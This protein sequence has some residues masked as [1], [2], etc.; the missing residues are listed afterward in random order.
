MKTPFFY[1]VFSLVLANCIVSDA[2]ILY[3]SYDL[4]SNNPFFLTGNSIQENRMINHRGIK[5]SGYAFQP[6]YCDSQI[7]EQYNSQTQG[8]EILTTTKMQYDGLMRPI[9]RKTYENLSFSSH[10]TTS[11]LFFYD[12]MDR[13]AQI[14]TNSSQQVFFD[15]NV[16]GDLV[17]AQLFQR[18]NNQWVLTHSDSNALTY[19]NNRL[20]SK[21]SYTKDPGVPNYFA[22]TR[23]L[24]LAFDL[25]NQLTQHFRQQT[26][27]PNLNWPNNFKA[28]VNLEWEM[29]YPTKHWEIDNR[30]HYLGYLIALPNNWHE[31]LPEP[32]KGEYYHV[33]GLNFTLEK[34]L[35]NEGWLNNKLIVYEDYSLSPNAHID[36]LYR[37]L[38]ERDPLGR[39]I[40]HQVDYK[41][42]RIDTTST[43]WPEFA[44]RWTYDIDNRLLSSI[45]YENMNAL[46]LWMDSTVIER[47][48]E[49]TSDPVPQVF[50]FTDSLTA[51]G[52]KRPHLRHTYYYG[53]FALP[54]NELAQQ[55]EFDIY[56]NP[57]NAIIHLRGLSSFGS[58]AEVRIYNAFGQLTLKEELYPEKGNIQTIPLSALPK[59]IYFVLIEGPN[60]MASQPLVIQ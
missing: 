14:R 2:Q 47:T 12:T 20:F 22:H 23:N 3:P 11:L 45:L 53:N 38:Y 60:G 25:N 56:P 42:R 21:V 10:D 32:T 29:G 52:I 24:N 51:N 7:V 30:P 5:L 34:R 48:Y 41:A 26:P 50:R 55:P 59:G 15:Y 44:Y 13:I 35:K 6:V 57:A 49:F 43:L 27:W 58:K 9:L 46:G 18:I 28:E 8:F 40:Y 31:L 1:L 17:L 54:V 33:E 19:Q 16:F 37:R 4:L 39:L 36:T